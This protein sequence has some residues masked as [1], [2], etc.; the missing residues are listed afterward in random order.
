MVQQ[1]LIYSA[2]RCTTLQH[3]VTHYNTL[4][5]AATR[6]D[7]QQRAATHCTTLQHTC[8]LLRRDDELNNL[9][10]SKSA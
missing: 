1:R 6:C 3:A 10:A 4:Q 5:Y 9:S 2:T 8:A 7:T